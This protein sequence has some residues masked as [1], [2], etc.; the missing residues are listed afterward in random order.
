M[1][2]HSS[3]GVYVREIDLS[4]TVRPATLSIG[5]IVGSSR[6]G[7]VGERTLITSIKQFLQ[8]F[9]PPDPTALPA[10]NG[11][12]FNTGAHFM[13][14]AALQFLT[15]SSQLLVTRVAPG[16]RTGGMTVYFDGNFN[17]AES[18][19]GGT[20]YPKEEPF[21]PDDLF[22][23]YGANPGVWNDD[24]SIQ[25]IPNPYTNDASF[26]VQVFQGSRGTSVESFLVTLYESIDGFGRQTNI[27]SV[28]NDQNGGSQYIRVS[29]NKTQA[30]YVANNRRTLINSIVAG[31]GLTLGVPLFGGSDGLQP[32]FGDIIQAW[33][34]YQDVE[35]V[36][37]NMLING[38][39]SVP[40]IQQAMCALAEARMDCVAILDMPSN[41]Q[42]VQSALDYRRNLLNLDSSYAALYSP[43]YLIH[44]RY[45]NIQLYV[46]PSGHI[47][48][49]YA[50]TDN[51]YN[52]WFAPAGMNRGDLKVDGVRHDYNQGDRDAL[53]ESQI[54]PTR[55]FEGRGIKIWG[56]DTLQSKQ[57]SLSNI[58]V[59][60]LMIFLEK[61]MA[62]AALYSVFDPND[63]I[64][65]A[66]LVDLCERFLQ[67]IMDARGLYWF[68]VQCDEHNNPPESIAN[69]DV[70]LDVYVDP[71]IPV[72]RIHLT[73]VVN[74][75]GSRVM[76]GAR[77]NG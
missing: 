3:A 70:I 7:P 17:A 29:Q 44:D 36:D 76:E 62:E 12:L 43:D 56:Q 54:N 53:V 18:W 11:G 25:I 30:D 40:P 71:S 28:I 74:K 10:Q 51:N 23:V 67:P 37:V 57:S 34:L 4:Q 27:E 20:E 65:R 63:A 52:V 5:A 9:G 73:A 1:A 72:K 69:G 19:T 35:Q 22:H 38:G 60:R 41:S 16:A 21:G 31:S 50:F 49:A 66:F 42:T 47:A 46:P 39:Y 26:Y 68:G 33:D 75:T 2:K 64:L 55:V 77:N 15:E 58:S 13:H 24:I 14:Y 48:A 6:R 59:R 61:S 8:V 45:N 32:T